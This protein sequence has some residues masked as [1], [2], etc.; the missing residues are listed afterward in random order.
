MFIDFAEGS[1]CLNFHR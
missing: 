1:Y